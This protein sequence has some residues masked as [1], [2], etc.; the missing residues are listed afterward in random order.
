VFRECHQGL[1]GRP[2]RPR[3]ED[4]YQDDCKNEKGWEE[5]DVGKLKDGERMMV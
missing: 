3:F 1:Q 2:Q 5:G 4:N